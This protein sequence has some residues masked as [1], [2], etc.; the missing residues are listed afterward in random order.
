MVKSAVMRHIVLTNTAAVASNTVFDESG[1]V[2][3][4]PKK[5]LGE[6]NQLVFIQNRRLP[7]AR[8]AAPDALVGGKDAAQD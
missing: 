1:P 5:A 6:K 2:N 3:A 7:G 4:G 8:L